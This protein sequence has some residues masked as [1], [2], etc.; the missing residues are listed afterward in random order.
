MA[1]VM[2]V[3]GDEAAVERIA[4]LLGRE[5]YIVARAAA[6]GDD[7]AQAARRVRDHLERRALRVG[8]L[9][10]DV[11]TR[12]VRRGTLRIELAPREYDLLVHL[13]RHAGQVVGREALF[14]AVWRFRHERSSNVVDV[15]VARLRRKLHAAGAEPLLH[16]VRGVGYMLADARQ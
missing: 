8:E 9:A 5:G 1:V 11:V 4:D 12:D 13:M 6:P 14:E 2:I 3:D 15:H 10:V 16:T 7:A